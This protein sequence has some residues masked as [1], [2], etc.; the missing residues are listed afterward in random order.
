MI[1]EILLFGFVGGVIRGLVGFIKHQFSYRDVGFNLP[2]FF[3]MMFL[4]GIIGLVVAYVFK[5]SPAFSLIVG[6][7]GGGFIENGYKTISKKKSLYPVK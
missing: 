6:Y 3:T 4:S 5:Q 2:R 7:A 1:W